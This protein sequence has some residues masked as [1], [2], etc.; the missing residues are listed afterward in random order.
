MSGRFATVLAEAER[1]GATVRRSWP[2][3][4]EHLLL[5]LRRD[6][7]ALAGQWFADPSRAAHVAARTG[8]GATALGGLVVQPAGADR[9]LP[10]LRG[11][12]AEPGAQ[13]VVHRPER[14]A[15]VRSADGTWTKLVRPE[16]L[17]ALVAASRPVPGV[18]T[19]EV[20][21]VDEGRAAVTTAHLPGVALHELLRVGDRVLAAAAAAGRLL[22]A[23]HAAPVPADAPRHDAAAELAVLQRWVGHARAYG[24][25]ELD[26]APVAALLAEAPAGAALLHRDLHDKQLLVDDDGVV[27]VLDLDLAAVGEPALDLANVLVHLEL[28]ALQGADADLTAAAGDA[29]LE[30]YAPSSAVRARLPAYAAATRLR[31]AAVY[32]FRPAARELVPRLRAG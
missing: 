11:L 19:A 32:A 9:R 16:R 27:G 29:L 10:A 14:R 22:A 6:G 18:R 20:L 25:L 24:L 4:P 30:A 28:R 26:V 5:D 7:A 8:A 1:A 17:G 31:L 21:S 13:L 12:V 3:G 15:V 2:R 23:L